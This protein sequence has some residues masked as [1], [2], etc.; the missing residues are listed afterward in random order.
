MADPIVA[1]V[2][3]WVAVGAA[4][5]AAAL[6]VA[7]VVVTAS[8]TPLGRARR[9]LDRIVLVLIGLVAVAAVIGPVVLLVVGRPADWLHLVY[10]A[11]AIAAAPTAR[12]IAA[13]RQSTRMGLWMTAG[14]LVTLGALLRLWVTG[15]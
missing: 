5:A 2:H 9:W 12:A 15:G 8:S 1:Q 10:A 6:M 11:I 7:G 4:V 13:W 14:S 3:A